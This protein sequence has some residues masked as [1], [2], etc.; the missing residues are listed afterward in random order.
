MES[1]YPLSLLA[2]IPPWPRREAD[3][4]RPSGMREDL[5]RGPNLVSEKRRRVRRMA[6]NYASKSALAG[7]GLL[8]EDSDPAWGGTAWGIPCI[9]G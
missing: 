5:R 7:E 3:E 6:E 9:A 2:K 4:S 1:S 8:L